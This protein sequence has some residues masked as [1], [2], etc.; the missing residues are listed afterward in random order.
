MEEFPLSSAS[1][2]LYTIG[3]YLW[4]CLENR[5]KQSRGRVAEE[6]RRLRDEDIYRKILKSIKKH[7]ARE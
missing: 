7:S 4:L 6:A 1:M 2:S 5:Q 3:A